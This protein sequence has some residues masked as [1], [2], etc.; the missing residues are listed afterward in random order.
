L[1]LLVATFGYFA[2]S[3]VMDVVGRKP[4]IIASYIMTII[5]CLVMATAA[6]LVILGIGRAILWTGIRQE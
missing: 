4:A 3:S 6:N 2:I 1:P 5:G